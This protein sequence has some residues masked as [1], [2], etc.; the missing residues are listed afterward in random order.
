MNPI[1]D[2]G[3]NF[4]AGLQ[5]SAPW[6]ATPARFLASWA[7]RVLPV[8]SALPLLVCG[9]PPGP[10]CRCPLDCVRQPEHLF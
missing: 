2:W 10:A 4:I 7:P 8:P 5:T 1:L 9:C 6:L 3:I